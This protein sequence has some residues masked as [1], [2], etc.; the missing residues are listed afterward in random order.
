MKSTITTVLTASALLISAHAQADTCKEKVLA[1]YNDMTPMVQM[2]EIESLVQTPGI[3]E[4]NGVSMNIATE[5]VSYGVKSVVG[6]FVWTKNY[7]EILVY[8][9]ECKLVAKKAFQVK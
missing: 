5:G 2:T 9:L 4:A 1:R 6:N 8:D 7:Y 3:V